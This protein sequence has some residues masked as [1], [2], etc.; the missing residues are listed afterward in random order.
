MEI[1][2]K[3]VW[4]CVTLLWWM[5]WYEPT[6]AWFVYNLRHRCFGGED[7]FDGKHNVA[8]FEREVTESKRLPKSIMSIR[9]VWGSEERSSWEGNNI[10]GQLSW[11]WI[12]LQRFTDLVRKHWYQLQQSSCRQHLTKRW[13][14]STKGWVSCH[15]HWLTAYDG[16]SV[17][18][19]GDRDSCQKPTYTSASY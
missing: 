15:Y 18:H 7:R 17:S 16:L 6:W 4:W 12:Y 3:Y 10:V 5:I 11:Q 2:T 1:S 19:C 8:L 13:L 9:L 14:V